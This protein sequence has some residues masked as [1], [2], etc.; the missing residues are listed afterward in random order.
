MSVDRRSSQLRSSPPRNLVDESLFKFLVDLEVEKAERLQ[1]C[2]SVVCLSPQ[3]EATDPTLAQRTAEV[4]SRT[5]RSTDIVSALSPELVCLLLID[6]ETRDLEQIFSRTASELGAHAL[7][8]EP[9][10]ERVAWSAGGSCYP[11]TAMTGT[12]L[13][14]QATELTSR[15]RGEGES[16]LRLPE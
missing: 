1:Y 9:T 14:R 10:G 6:A 15:A 3:G 7:T 13:I 16:A 4:A 12:E 5:F 2:V 11:L 8:A